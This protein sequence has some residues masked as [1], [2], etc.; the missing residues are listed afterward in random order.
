MAATTRAVSPN[1]SPHTEP[2]P[3]LE[4]NPRTPVSLASPTNILPTANNTDTTNLL[5]PHSQKADLAGGDGSPKSGRLA[6][7]PV[8]LTGVAAEAELRKR[9]LQQERSVEAERETSPNPAL[10]AMQT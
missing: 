2:F 4:T 7:S 8:T 5:R 1:T 6:A 10:Q 3:A 9:K